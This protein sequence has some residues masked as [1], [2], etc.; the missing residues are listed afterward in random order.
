MHRFLHDCNYHYFKGFRV[1]ITSKNANETQHTT[2]CTCTI[3]YSSLLP[4]GSTQVRNTTYVASKTAKKSCNAATS[5]LQTP[6]TIKNL[7]DDSRSRYVKAAFNC[8][9]WPQTFLFIRG[10]IP[11]CVAAT[12]QTVST[13]H[14]QLCMHG[15]LMKFK[16]A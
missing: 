2:C 6:R 1:L 13:K 10:N 7:H 16:P 12:I 14:R 9:I 8:E 3:M 11:S 4:C 15:A 5:D